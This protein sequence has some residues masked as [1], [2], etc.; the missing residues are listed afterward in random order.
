MPAV[1]CTPK[2]FFDFFY[3][4]ISIRAGHFKSWLLDGNGRLVPGGGEEE[5]NPQ[6]YRDGQ[7]T[8]L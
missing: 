8:F 2:K 4:L 7:K 5:V 1:W 3:I 6:H